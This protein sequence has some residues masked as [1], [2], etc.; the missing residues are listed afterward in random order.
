MSRTQTIMNS[1][2]EIKSGYVH[3]GRSSFHFCIELQYL[4]NDRFWFHCEC[5]LVDSALMYYCIISEFGG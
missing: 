4:Q 3:F 2:E 1:N 5:N